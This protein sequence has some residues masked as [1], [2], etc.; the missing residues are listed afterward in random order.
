MLSVPR[1]HHH[2]TTPR[3]RQG[4]KRYLP[5][6]KLL[7]YCNATGTGVPGAKFLNSSPSQMTINCLLYAIHK[8]SPDPDS[9]CRLM[10]SLI[11]YGFRGTGT[12]IASGTLLLV[13][14]SCRSGWM[15]F[16]LYG[17]ANSFETDKFNT[18]DLSYNNHSKT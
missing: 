7:V 2:S 8:H 17:D 11:Q 18:S 3:R 4:V 13:F 14:L 5:A 16:S 6:D 9:W 10:S 1:P 12:N 15:L